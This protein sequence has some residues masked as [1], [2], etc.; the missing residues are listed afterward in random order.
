MYTIFYTPSNFRTGSGLSYL[1]RDSVNDS[2]KF[3]VGDLGAP[4]ANSVALSNSLG[5][6]NDIKSI[7][8]IFDLVKTKKACIN[9]DGSTLDV[10]YNPKE[11]SKPL[12]D[13]IDSKLEAN[14]DKPTSEFSCIRN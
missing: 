12:T 5:S 9:Y 2:L 6:Q 4:E 13:L 14:K 11:I 1:Y 8:A 10:Y 7:K 3:Y